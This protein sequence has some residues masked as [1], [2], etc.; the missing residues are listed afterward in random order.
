MK[1]LLYLTISALLA[2]P[3]FAQ[4]KNYLDHLSDYIENTSVFEENQEAGH[5]YF[6]P[7]KH[8]SLNGTWRFL[9]CNAPTA[10][11]KDFFRTGFNDGKWN[12]IEVPSNWEMKGFGDR[13][14]RNVHAPFALQIPEG[15]YPPAYMRYMQRTPTP[16]FAVM[17]P[18]VPWEYNPTGAYRRT[19]TV[20][21]D[22]KGEQILLRM[23]KTASASFVW[24]N[25]EQV[26]YNEGAQEPAE[27][28]ITKYVKPGKNT[29]AVC[30]LK[31]SDGFYLE[32]QDYWRLAGIFDDVWI[33]AAPKTRLYDWQIITDLDDAYRDATLKVKL[34]VKRYDAAASSNYTLKAVL[35]DASGAQ[36]TEM[37][38]AVFAMK[39]KGDQWIDLSTAVQNPKKWTSE[40]PVLYTL[41]M[42]LLDANG[43]VVDQ[44]SQRIGFK[45]TLIKGDTFFLNGVPVKISATNSHMQDP[46]MGHRMTEAVIRKDFEILKQHN[47]NAVRTSHYPPVNKYL[48]LADEYGLFIIDETGDESH[49]TEYVSNLPAFIPMYQERVRR[50]VLRDRNH[51]CILFW[52]AG[53]ESG[54]GPDITEVVK[55]GKKYDPT[56]YW[57]YG[58]NSFSHPAEDIIG[59]RYP[60]PSELEM[61]VAAE[62]DKNDIRPSFMD[63]YLSVA[64]NGGG[65]LDDYW[66]VIYNHPRTMGGAIWDFVSPGLTEHARTLTDQSPFHTQ[67]VMMGNAKLVSLGKKQANKVLDLN[68]HDQWVEVYR[69]NNLEIAGDKLTLTCRLFPRKLVSSCGSFI[70]KG[71]YQYG[72]QQHGKDSLDF[73]IYNGKKQ[74]LRVAL[75][76][77]WEEHWH[78]LS[79]VYDGKQMK[80]FIDNREAGSM[81]AKGNIV[82]FPFPVNIGRNEEEHGQ[83][84]NVYICDAQ[85]DDV[86]I[87]ADAITPDELAK[88]KDPAEKSALWL[89][90]EEE[91]DAGTYFSYGIGA[92]TY[93]S[94]W[95]DRRPQ[96]EMEQ[97][98]HSTQ[99]IVATLLDETSGSVEMTNHFNFLN[100]SALA[101]Y[102]TLTEDTTVLQQ[103]E[104][105]PDIAAQQSKTVQIPIGS[106]TKQPGKEY[107]I[108]L[109]STLKNDELW[110][111]KGFEVAWNQLELGGRASL[112]ESTKATSS[113]QLTENDSQTIA[114]GNGFEYAFD[115]QSGLLVSMKVNGKEMLDEPLEMNVWRAPL[116]NE[117]DQWNSRTAHSQKWK[118]GFGEMTATEWYSTGI[119]RLTHNLESF[120]CEQAGSKVVVSVRTF[121]QTNESSVGNRDLYIRGQEYNGFENI[122]TYTI[123]GNGEITLHHSIAPQGNMPMWLPRIGLKMMLNKSLDNVTYYGRGPEENYTDRKT[124]YKVG[125]YTTT[126][127]KMYEPYLIPQDN[128]LRTDT[129][130]LKMTDANG[131]GLTFCMNELFNFNTS[132]YSTDNLTKASYTY[133]LQPAKGLTLNLDYATTGVG[134][135]ARSTFAAYRVYPAQY[136]REV[137]I[138]PIK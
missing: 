13:M 9:F 70:T 47:F 54:E 4:Q 19:F 7:A 91:H 103:G 64:G 6:V 129:R 118:E 73:Y 26:G 72:L 88:L 30:V 57:M 17:P 69:G 2:T 25:G 55:E 127:E 102:W 111:K 39:E 16:P 5:A 96:P 136:V 81:E 35:N 130:W 80:V 23:E 121:D 66:R 105:S 10:V 33:Y 134:C 68:G 48:E 67:T 89:T 45:E 114:K 32:G 120:R 79:G 131:K 137:I 124:G 77:D 14:F 83:E 82:N 86:G 115:K 123:D 93:G 99:P 28:D 71:N 15:A 29:I 43:Q 51:P 84:T 49:A 109:S 63:E 132:I 78:Q 110:A 108:N 37:K 18:K 36:V 112:P 24:I 100:A 22:W 95:P 126:A 8:L 3:L 59:P 94:I 40:T 60:S 11:P 56:R 74:T 42:E 31:F 44:A 12:S 97:M 101:T 65:G 34:N 41:K 85:L 61:Q 104:L 135:T 98:K 38:S 138:R 90:F 1:R 107:R 21:S 106:F 92:R 62:P 87:F 116:A 76:A 122:F 46:E 52:S 20:P 75:P 119:D 125:I 113:V 50:M 27:Y 117:L 128:G 58:G 133:Q 53:N